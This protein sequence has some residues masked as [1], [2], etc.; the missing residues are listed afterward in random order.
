MPAFPGAE[1]FGA[2]NPGG[3]GGRVIR[4]TNLNPD[5]PGSLQAACNE[6][7]PRIVVFEV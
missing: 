5:G 7:G 3:R 1:G 4:V 6:Q 2:D